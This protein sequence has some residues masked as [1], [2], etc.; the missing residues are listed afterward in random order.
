[1]LILAK[2]GRSCKGSKAKIGYFKHKSPVDKAITRSKLSVCS[3][4][5][6]VQICHSL[7]ISRG[8]YGLALKI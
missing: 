3:Y 6:V 1:M 2:L 5:A 7:E 8:Y 4:I